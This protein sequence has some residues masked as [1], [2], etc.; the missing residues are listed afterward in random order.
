MAVFGLIQIY[1]IKSRAVPVNDI[2]DI[3]KVI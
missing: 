3:T 2:L 1:V